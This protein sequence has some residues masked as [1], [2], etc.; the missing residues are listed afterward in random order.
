[1]ISN[2]FETGTPQKA[3]KRNF[4]F[5]NASDQELIKYPGQ[6]NGNPFKLSYLSNCTVW[7]LDVLATIN[8]D[9]CD[10]CNLYLGPV[11]NK[12]ELQDL[13]NCTVAVATKE[14]KCTNCKK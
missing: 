11:S 13:E 8:A 14:I 1:M 5:V 3:D 4:I 2:P 9:N 12:V 7:L 6:V 10:G